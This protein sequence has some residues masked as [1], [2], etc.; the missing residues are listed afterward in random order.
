MSYVRLVP[1]LLLLAVIVAS[2]P[3]AGQPL[4]QPKSPNTAPPSG[5]AVPGKPGT[6]PAPEPPKADPVAQKTLDDTIAYLEK[7]PI[8]WFDTNLWQQIDV[9]GLLF[10]SEGKYQYGPG[11]RLSLDF[12]LRTG[13]NTGRLEMVCDGTTNWETH[14]VGDSKKYIQRLDWTK[15]M[16]T[17][18]QGAAPPE[19]RELFLTSKSFGG[20]LPFIKTLRQSLTLTKQ[21]NVAWID[22]VLDDKSVTKTVERPVVKLTGAWSGELITKPIPANM[23]PPVLP[24]QCC[25][26]LDEKTHCVCRVEWWGPVVQGAADSLLLQIEFRDAKINVELSEDRSAQVFKYNPGDGPVQDVTSEMVGQLQNHLDRTK[27]LPK[28]K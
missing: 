13:E 4:A 25:L 2:S 11:F 14:Q 1:F 27:S 23:W 6:P 12:R 7:H 20:I 18:R 26:Y 8:V 5:P 15:V 28:R 17:F 3:V 19:S 24:R 16:N 21:E 9:Q 10:Q 22:H